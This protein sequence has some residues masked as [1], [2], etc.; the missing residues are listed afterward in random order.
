[1][2]NSKLFNLPSCT[3]CSVL[4]DDVYEFNESKIPIIWDEPE[5][6]P[7]A[8][9]LVSI[10]VSI[11]EVK[12]SN[13]VNLAFPLV[14]A[15]STLSKRESNDCESILYEPVFNLVPIEFTN[16]WVAVFNSVSV[17]NP[18][19]KDDENDSNNVN[20]PFWLIFNK[21]LDCVYELKE[22][23]F[24]FK[25]IE[26]TKDW[27]AVFNSTSVTKVL[28]SD[29]E[30]DSKLFN[31]LFWLILI[32]AIDEVYVLNLEL[33]RYIPSI[34]PLSTPSVFNLSFTLPSV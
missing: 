7:S 27:V 32:E 17:T 1:M 3:D 33:V 25:S 5:I 21:S 4:F 20:L 14:F 16:D 31:L 6:I 12:S 24:N 30:N 23:I 11:D 2:Y 34:E 19:S 13:A 22:E 10:V 9:N 29:D 28:S 18:A 15:D 26:S 8:S